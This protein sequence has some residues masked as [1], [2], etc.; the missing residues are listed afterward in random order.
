MFFNINSCIQ[1]HCFL[2]IL[3]GKRRLK[4]FIT[5]KSKEELINENFILNKIYC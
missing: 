4:I 1:E 2:V 5:K 3:K